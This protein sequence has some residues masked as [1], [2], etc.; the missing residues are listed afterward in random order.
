M[1]VVKENPLLHPLLW[2]SFWRLKLR[3]QHHAEAQIF[4]ASR[5]H[6]VAEKGNVDRATVPAAATIHAGIAYRTPVAA[7][8]KY[9]PAHIVNTQRVGGSGACVPS[10][11]CSACIL[12]NPCHIFCIVAAAVQVGR[13]IPAGS[14]FGCIFLFGFGRQPKVFAQTRVNRNTQLV[15]ETE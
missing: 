14:A 9:V 1:S 8:L 7:P 6:T 10:T 12:I 3:S 2:R 15:T 13:G 5:G 4:G 11:A